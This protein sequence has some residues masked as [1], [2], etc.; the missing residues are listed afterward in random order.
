MSKNSKV[1]KTFSYLA[2]LTGSLWS[3]A[4]LMRLF[5]FYWLFEPEDFIL[6]SY[7]NSDNIS[8]LVYT[9]LPAITTTM[10]LYSTFIV[11]FVLFLVTTNLKFKENGWL[12]ISTVVILITLPFEMYLIS[13][14]Y[15]ITEILLSS[16]YSPEIVINLIRKRFQVLG[17]FSLVELFSYFS[18]FYFILFQPFTKARN[19]D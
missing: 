1:A 3:G 2:V 6:K 4:Y 15:N 18:L 5:L 19:E 13:I 7:I 14:D 10:V 9:L 8:S 12:F 11:F 16:S 17:N